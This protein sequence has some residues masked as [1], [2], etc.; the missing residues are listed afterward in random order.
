MNGKLEINILSHAESI[1][2][3]FEENNCSKKCVKKYSISK[4]S[5]PIL[6][7]EPMNEY[8]SERRI[9]IQVEMRVDGASITNY[10]AF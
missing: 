1:I 10:L 5:Y 8:L 9:Q 3:A 2:Y 6:T 4:S 7:E